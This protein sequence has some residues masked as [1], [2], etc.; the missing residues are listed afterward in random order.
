MAFKEFE[1]VGWHVP[2]YSPIEVAGLSYLAKIELY[3][4]DTEPPAGSKTGRGKYEWKANLYFYANYKD[5]PKHSLEHNSDF[6]IDLH[7]HMSKF[8]TILS[9]IREAEGGKVNCSYDDDIRIASIKSA[10]K[11]CYKQPYL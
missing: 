9:L 1:V 2:Y 6:R 7:F 3:S 4:R 11:S 8:P 5:V 10:T